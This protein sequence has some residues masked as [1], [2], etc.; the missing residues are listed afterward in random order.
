MNTKQ[1]G[2]R[3]VLK[4]IAAGSSA[5]LPG[6]SSIESQV[7]GN[8]R[9]N[10]TVVKFWTFFAGG[11]GQAM[12][13]IVDRFNEEQPLG[14]ITIERQRIPWGRY[15]TKLYTALV[16]DKGPDIASMHQALMGRFRETLLPL[17]PYL[18][19]VSSDMYAGDLWDRLR[20]EDQQLGLPLDTHPIGAY[21]NKDLFEA[22]GLD[23]ESPPT[24]FQEFEDACNT[25]VS[26]TDAHAFAPDPDLSGNPISTLRTFIA[27][28]RQ[29]GGRM[30]N[31]DTTQVRFDEDPGVATAKFYHNITGEYEWDIPNASESRTDVAFQDGNLGIVMNGSWYAPVLE[32]VDGLNW[33]LFKPFISPGKEENY[34]EAGSHTVVLPQNPTRN[35]ETTQAAVK[36]MEWLTQNNLSW[37]TVAGHL[38][39]GT[40]VLN[41]SELQESSLWPKTISKHYEMTEENQITYLPRTP[42]N[43]N[44]SSTWSFLLDIYTHT[45]TPEEGIARGARSVQGLIDDVQ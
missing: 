3:R 33:G 13:S 23:P 42:F 17:D 38:P 39:A 34:T 7:I 35:E 29:R 16:A 2:R 27:F 22:A 20:F 45:T 14:D 36:V 4:G 28:N 37:G 8:P 31:E 6:C 24:N 19:Q 21:Y 12:A 26:E 40:S 41:S 30:F 11:D 15:Y 9:N 25:I 44:E 5:G 32:G 1:I 18:E 10:E 43:V